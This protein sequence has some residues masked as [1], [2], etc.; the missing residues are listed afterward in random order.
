ML[1][2]RRLTA[3][4]VNVLLIQVNLAGY[5]RTCVQGGNSAS[6]ATNMATMAHAPNVPGEAESARDDCAAEQACP[7]PW[8]PEGCAAATACVAPALPASVIVTSAD[9]PARDPVRA[10]TALM[11]QG[12]PSAPDLPPPRA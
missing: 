3:L 8:I 7:H 4:V 12:P 5:G 6:Q 11:W 9:T 1:R 2:L 10:G